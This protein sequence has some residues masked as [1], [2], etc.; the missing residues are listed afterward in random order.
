MR[1]EG[2]VSVAT[3]KTRAGRIQTA[4]QGNGK[5]LIGH[6]DKASEPQHYFKKHR[7]EQRWLFHISL[8]HGLAFLAKRLKTNVLSLGHLLLNSLLHNFKFK[9]WETKF[10][11]LLSEAD[12]PGC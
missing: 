6:L 9:R 12:S 4:S 1:P 8:A 2:T 7:P 11:N 10:S 3:S 5:E